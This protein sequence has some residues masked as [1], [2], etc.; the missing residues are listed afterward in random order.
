[1]VS[2]DL[3]WQ[4]PSVS[5]AA[6]DLLYLWTEQRLRLNHLAI[7]DSTA[8]MQG[9]RHRLMQ[10]AR[11][12]QSPAVLLVFD[13]DFETCF[14]RDQGRSQAVGKRVLRG[15]FK[16]FRQQAERLANEGWDRVITLNDNDQSHAPVVVE[17]LSHE[18]PESTG[19]FDIV[20]DVHGCLSELESLLERL[21]WR[22]DPQGVPVHPDGRQLIFVGDL[23]CG[24]PDSVG[25]WRLAL[26]LQRVGRANILLGDHD[27]RFARL[28]MGKA[29]ALDRG[30]DRVAG[31]LRALSPQQVDRLTHAVR[32]LLRDAP[33]HLL[34]DGGRLAVAH[35]ALPDHMVGKEGRAVRDFC[36]HAE[37]PTHSDRGGWVRAHQG[38]ELV[39]HGHAPTATPRIINH[40]LNI[41]TGC[42]LGGQLTALRWPERTLVQVPATAEHWQ[43]GCDG[44]DATPPADAEDLTLESALG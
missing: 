36:R 18:R 11:K 34:L 17:P 40:T 43:D 13:S 27:V 24:G 7:V 5:Q 39:V 3:N 32:R 31:E 4:L 25:A 22:P 35:A 6:F 37:G 26:R 10:L 12:W 1:M 16:L 15:Q 23:G 21:G 2:D 8:L 19:P 44:W 29:P 14:A 20:G 41:D 38:H 42:V 9:T 33:S 28:L 30:L